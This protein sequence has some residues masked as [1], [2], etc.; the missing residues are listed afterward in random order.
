MT[1]ERIG[2]VDRDGAIKVLPADLAS[3]AERRV[4]LEGEAKVLASLNHPDIGAI[5]ASMRLTASASSRWSWFPEKTW[6]SG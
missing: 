5:Y 1:L 3:D 2:A 4:R 6:R